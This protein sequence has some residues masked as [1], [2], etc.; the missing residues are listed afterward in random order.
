MIRGA[1]FVTLTR[2]DT[3]DLPR[4]VST[5]V[6][7]ELERWLADIEGFQG[8]VMLAR[9]GSSVALSFWESREA[10]ER[11]GTARAQV[12]ERVTELAGAKIE[13]VVEYEVAFA[14]VGPLMVDPPT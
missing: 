10:A 11:H 1:V 5:I 7:E 13:E 9:D 14:H 8:L 2:V 12:R 4:E 3:G 6:A